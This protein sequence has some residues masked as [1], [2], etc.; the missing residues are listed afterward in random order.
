M[1]LHLVYQL[2]FCKFGKHELEVLISSER[3]NRS[4]LGLSLVLSLTQFGSHPAL[5]CSHSGL[6]LV[7]PNLSL[8]SDL[9]PSSSE[10]NFSYVP[11]F[12]CMP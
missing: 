11:S 12:H 8:F 4:N 10:L 5:M 2:V 3:V 7:L 6:V 9:L 1:A